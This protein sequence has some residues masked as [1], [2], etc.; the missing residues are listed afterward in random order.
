[1]T[2]T[3]PSGRQ[4]SMT[5]EIASGISVLLVVSSVAY[6]VFFSVIARRAFFERLKREGASLSKTIAAGS[7]YYVDFR[8]EANLRDIAQSLLL[9]HSVDYVEFLDA[10]GKMLAQSD[11]SKR[12]AALGTSKPLPPGEFVFAAPV[13]DTPADARVLDRLGVSSRTELAKLSED[14]LIA[15]GIARGD[16]ENFR[17][18]AIVGTL[19]LA[20]NSSD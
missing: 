6:L 7:G 10:D 4:A 16:V 11:N 12:P 13:A 15:A 18:S 8:L 2:T 5:R 9:N 19:R 20:M 14:A 17:K 1:M 3:T